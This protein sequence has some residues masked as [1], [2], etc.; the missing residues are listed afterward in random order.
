MLFLSG[1]FSYDS[2]LIRT[3]I[4]CLLLL[5]LYHLPSKRHSDY[6]CQNW[7]LPD[8]A[9]LILHTFQ[10]TSF[11]LPSSQPSDPPGFRP[12]S[13]FY[14]SALCT[15]HCLLHNPRLTLSWMRTSTRPPGLR[16]LFSHIHP[17]CIYVLSPAYVII[18]G[19]GWIYFLS[20]F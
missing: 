19:V 6:S 7:C 2:V 20:F 14:Y 3:L 8:F 9:M 16:W 17:G 15:P 10:A 4:C 18:L 1:L 13:A 5:S 11:W 12:V